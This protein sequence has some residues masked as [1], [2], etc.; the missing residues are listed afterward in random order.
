VKIDLIA[1]TADFGFYRDFHKSHKKWM[2]CFAE[3]ADAS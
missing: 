1:A 2:R 3:S